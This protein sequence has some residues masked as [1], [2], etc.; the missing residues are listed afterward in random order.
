MRIPGTKVYRAFPEFDRFTEEQCRRLLAADGQLDRT[1]LTREL[2]VCG[3]GSIVTI[4][5]GVG[6]GWVLEQLKPA[7]ARSPSLAPVADGAALA[8]LLL[9][10]FGLMLGLREWLLRRQLRTILR[11]KTDCQKCGYP[12]LGLAIQPD[13]TALCP[14]CGTATA[15]RGARLDLSGRP[16]AAPEIVS[17][18]RDLRLLGRRRWRLLGLLIFRTGATAGAVLLAGALFAGYWYL[19]SERDAARAVVVLSDTGPTAR[20]I[21]ALQPSGG[22]GAAENGM[23]IL[24]MAERDRASIQRDF[25]AKFYQS[26]EDARTDFWIH[27]AGDLIAARPQAAAENDKAT[28]SARATRWNLA[29]SLSHEWV[30]H[31]EVSGYF[32]RLDRVTSARRFLPLD[33]EGINED[34]TVFAGRS[35]QH[36]HLSAFECN[37]QRLRLAVVR[38]DWGGAVRALRTTVGIARSLGIGMDVY[39]TAAGRAMVATSATTMAPLLRQAGEAELVEVKGLLEEAA[40]DLSFARAK[41]GMCVHVAMQTAWAFRTPEVTRWGSWSVF[42]LVNRRAPT[43]T[44]WYTLPAIGT[45]DGTLKRALDRVDRFY[46]LV[47]MLSRDRAAIGQAAAARDLLRRVGQPSDE[48]LLAWLEVADSINLGE[49]AI[50]TSIALERYRAKKGRYPESLV[51][52]VPE[53]LAAVPQEPWQ[54]G[55]LKYRRLAAPDAFGRGYLLYSVGLAGVNEPER[56]TALRAL[57]LQGELSLLPREPV[58]FILNPAD[59]PRAFRP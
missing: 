56:G 44:E 4:V 26:L 1:R 35:A 10:V 58:S 45:Y 40:S 24:A 43:L 52:L 5:A 36:F 28:L 19:R 48:D 50:A 2:K 15:V 49:T 29:I 46:E 31:L 6:L 54:P 16:T 51:E 7:L 39:T 33:N 37:Q 12:L 17:A 13:R 27:S 59:E 11:G 18:A 14:E 25:E 32:E 3:L 53:F 42:K 34:V 38:S 9:L 8:V 30:K 20:L 22:G 55:A 21:A 47:G 41:D 57:M 23:A